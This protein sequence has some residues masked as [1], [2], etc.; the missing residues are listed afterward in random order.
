[1]DSIRGYF[2][3]ILISDASSIFIIAIFGVSMNNVKSELTYKHN[4]FFG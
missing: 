4:P 2:Y 1:M 3:I